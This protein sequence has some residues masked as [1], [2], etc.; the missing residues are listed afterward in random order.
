MWAPWRMEYIKKSKK[1]RG[2][3][4][5]KKAKGKKDQKNYLLYRS[6]KSY[7][8]MNLYPYNNGHLM[9]AP[10]RHVGS[11]G[12]LTDDEICDMLLVAKKGV[13]ALKRAFKPEGFNIGM[14]VGKVAGAGVI[15][16][17]HMHIVPR[18]KGDT[19]FMPV[20]ADTKLVSESLDET[21][22]TLKKYM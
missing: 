8:I 19:N 7:C 21:Y 3:L 2:C 15:G 5:C 1:E 20:L 22:T 6:K 10:Y 4:F 12:S 14:N 11:I 18:W 13:A 17:L 16:H 9:I